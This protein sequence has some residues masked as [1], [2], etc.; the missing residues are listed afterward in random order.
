MLTLFERAARAGTPFH[1]NPLFGGQFVARSCARLVENM[2]GAAVFATTQTTSNSLRDGGAAYATRP[3]G[4]EASAANYTPS[5]IAQDD[6][7]LLGPI[8]TRLADEVLRLAANSAS[9]CV[10]F[11]G[12]GEP[13]LADFVQDVFVALSARALEL[14]ELRSRNAEIFLQAVDLVARSRL[15]FLQRQGRVLNV[16]HAI[17]DR[18]L[19]FRELQIIA[20]RDCCLYKV[21][22]VLQAGN[23]GRD[24]HDWHLVSRVVLGRARSRR[25]HHSACAPTD[26][27]GRAAA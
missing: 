11:Q 7:S 6:F 10:L 17:V 19:H 13:T 14:G 15:L 4:C 27:A 20:R 12:V 16:D 21:D 18:L 3:R 23:R 25:N 1:G 22:S 26:Q 2:E 24:S 5:L 9:V 8:E